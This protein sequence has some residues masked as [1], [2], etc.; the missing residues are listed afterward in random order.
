MED[1]GKEITYQNYIIEHMRF[2]DVI[3]VSGVKLYIYEAAL[4]GGLYHTIVKEYPIDYNSMV[5]GA[6]SIAVNHTLRS[7]P[8]PIK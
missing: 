5:W 3:I 8:L 6:I 4:S 2:I 1:K 7:E